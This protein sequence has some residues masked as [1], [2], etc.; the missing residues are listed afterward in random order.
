[1]KI[2][3]DASVLIAFV[4]PEETGHRTAARFIAACDLGGH[5]IIL[6]SLAWPEVAGSVARRKHDPT[7]AEVA[8]LRL[9]RLPRLSVLALTDPFTLAAA[10]LAGRHSLR[11]ADAIYVQAAR[12]SRASLVTLDSEMHSRA[13]E[14]VP[15]HTPA[16]WLR[17]LGL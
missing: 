7:K 1:M 12:H 13:K 5:H 11:G 6:P 10:R 14:I 15:T 2:V 16:E 3:V 4:L 9:T 17:E 8:I